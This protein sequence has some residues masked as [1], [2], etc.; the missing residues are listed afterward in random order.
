MPI[1]VR[2]WHQDERDLE[3]RRGLDP[4]TVA[5]LSMADFDAMTVDVNSLTFGATGDEKSLFRCSK[6]GHDVNHDGLVDLVCYFKPDVAN[7]QTHLNG[8]LRGRTKSGQQIKGSAAL[9][10]YSVPTEK[11]GF[12]LHDQHDNDGDDRKNGNDKRKK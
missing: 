1:E 6:N 4:I 11:R 7:F 5:I 12:K 9:K 2:H 10:I 3:K 8:V